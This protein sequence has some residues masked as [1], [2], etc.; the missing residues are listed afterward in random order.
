[1]SEQH[2]DDIPSSNTPNP[3]TVK[4]VVFFDGE[5]PLC[6]REISHYRRLSGAER[7]DWID[8]TLTHEFTADYGLS[9]EA[10]MARFHMLDVSGQWQTGMWGFAELWS[11]LPGYKRLASFL[12]ALHLLPALDRFY[13]LFAHWRLGR[14]CSEGVCNVTDK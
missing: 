10:A 12:R 1:M 4:P 13:T 9:R 6:R 7:L 5:C 2:L 8:I 3:A 14:R 11:Y